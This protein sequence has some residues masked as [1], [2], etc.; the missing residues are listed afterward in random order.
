MPSS[1]YYSRPVVK[2]ATDNI[3]DRLNN[4]KLRF[5]EH[6]S[7]PN[8]SHPSVEQ[9]SS[10]KTVSHVWKTGDRYYKL[11][12]QYYGHS[13]QWWVIAWFNKKPTEAHLTLGDVIQIPYPLE[14]VVAAYNI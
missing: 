11:A 1:R 13:E 14:K 9:A 2:N 5:I 12:N 4:K 3:K 8:M 6:F 10:I 7:T